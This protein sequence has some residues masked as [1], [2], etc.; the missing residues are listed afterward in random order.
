MARKQTV[1]T[2]INFGEMSQSE[3]TT[4]TIVL[5]N[6]G[7]LSLNNTVNMS[8]SDYSLIYDNFSSLNQREVNLKST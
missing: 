1:V 6:T 5:K 4:Q 2:N 7:N 3:S 8:G